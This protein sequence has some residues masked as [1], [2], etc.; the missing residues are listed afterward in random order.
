MAGYRIDR[1]SEDIKREIIDIM[2][3]LKDPWIQGLLR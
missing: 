3:D 2:R 1:T